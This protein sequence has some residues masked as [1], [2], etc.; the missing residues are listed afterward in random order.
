MTKITTLQE[1]IRAG[2]KNQKIHINPNVETDEWDGVWA[3]KEL[4]Q[5]NKKY[6]DQL[7]KDRVLYVIE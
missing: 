4:L 6:L 5:V 1:I 7:L 2:N 3:A